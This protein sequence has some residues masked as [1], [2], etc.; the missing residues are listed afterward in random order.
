MV[1]GTN[2]TLCCTPRTPTRYDTFNEN[3]SCVLSQ[4]EM[5]SFGGVPQPVRPNSDHAPKREQDRH[6][7][8]RDEL[9]IH[10]SEQFFK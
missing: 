8:C 10:R 6:N 7:A 5:S 4:W 3:I 2:Q 9:N 1:F